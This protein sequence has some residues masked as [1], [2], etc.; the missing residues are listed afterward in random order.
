MTGVSGGGKP[1]QGGVGALVVVEIEPA[2]DSGLSGAGFA[3]ESGVEALL[4]QGAVVAF[5]LAVLFRQSHGDELVVDAREAKGL[6]KRVGLLPV[7]EEALG[8]LRAMVGLDPLNRERESS[9]EAVEE[10]DAGLG[11]PWRSSGVSCGVGSGVSWPGRP[12]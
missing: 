7:R 6:F 4:V 10:K 9:E 1:A 2:A 8:E 11:P 12:A 3:K 5:R